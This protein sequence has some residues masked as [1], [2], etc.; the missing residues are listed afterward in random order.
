MLPLLNASWDW[1]QVWEVRCDVSK[2]ICLPLASHL[3]GIRLKTKAAVTTRS[4]DFM[5]VVISHREVQIEYTH[6]TL[7]P[8][9][10]RL[11]FRFGDDTFVFPRIN[12]ARSPSLSN[13]SLPPS[14]SS[15]PAQ[16]TRAFFSEYCTGAGN[17]PSH[18]L[19]EIG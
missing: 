4:D 8:L 2:S 19:R 11:L 16:K 14:A 1:S 10:V 15:L 3:Q 7:C 18:G 5:A 6:Y 17:I 13:L 9:S 12:Y